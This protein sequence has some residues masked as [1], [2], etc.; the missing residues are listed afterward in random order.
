M[1][2]QRSLAQIGLLPAAGLIFMLAVG[3]ATPDTWEIFDTQSRQAIQDS[4][5]PDMAAKLPEILPPPVLASDAA[6]ETVAE[7]DGPLELS[8]EQAAMLALQNN[9]DLR[10]HRINPAIAGTFEKIERGAYDPE[11]F[12]EMEFFEEKA[13]ETSRATGEQFGVQGT[14]VEIIAGVRQELPFGTTVEAAIE[15][16]RSDSDRAPDQQT[17]RVGLSITQSLLRG[18]GPAVNLAGVRQAEMDAAASLYEFRGFTETLIADTE[19]AYWQYVLAQQEI[20][21]FEQ[22]LAVVKQQ[23]DEIEYKIE[24]GLVPEIEAAAARAEVAT[25][26]QML[27]DARSLL[28]ERRIRLLRFLNISSG[29]PFAALVYPVSDP[30]IR[31]APMNDLEDRLMLADQSRPDLNEARMRQRQNRL[32]TVVTR[33]GL[34]PE[35]E[36]F[37]ALGRTGYADNFS[38]AVKALDD[39]TYDV[40]AGL[41][42]SSVAGNRAAEARHEAAGLSLRQSAEAVANL[43]QI[44]DMEVRLAMN[45]VERI[46]QQIV[47]SHATRMLEE[48]KLQ[49]EKERFDVGAGTSLLVAQ[50][51]RD[52][53]I[54]RIAEVR[55]VIHYRIALVNLYLAE[56][57]L[58]ERRGIRVE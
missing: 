50:A 37:A 7:T 11:V 39:S 3:C 45:E 24:V 40:S 43:R 31:P 55:S 23:R 44:V 4:H 28:E 25:N 10:V 32:E 20:A 8:V 29:R 42:L 58:L 15:H 1:Q 12:A 38:D 6:I 54:S 2:K 21:I 9:R 36:L 51:Q 18:F 26:E 52:L 41:R 56:G 19:I 33:N 22:S 14:D 5:E 13:S 27:I 35:L 30:F 47:A 53:L 17:A 48:E 34:L 16:D 49:A 46:R 57:S